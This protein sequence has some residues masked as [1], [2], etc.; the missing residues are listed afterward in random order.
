MPERE[1]ISMVTPCCS[2]E[3]S[4]PYFWAEVQR[5]MQKINYNV[6]RPDPRGLRQCRHP[7]G[8]PQGRAVHPLLLRPKSCT[9]IKNRPV[10]IVA[11]SKYYKGKGILL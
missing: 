8:H 1:R 4:L 5:V 9:E 6:P 2:E 3:Q 10:Y 11:E 7:P